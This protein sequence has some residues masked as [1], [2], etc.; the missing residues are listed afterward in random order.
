M[1]NYRYYLPASVRIFKS[2]G[3]DFTLVLFILRVHHPISM[4]HRRQVDMAGGCGP[5]GP[6]RPMPCGIAQRH[7][8]P[9][10]VIDPHDGL[11][12]ASL[13]LIQRMMLRSHRSLGPLSYTWRTKTDLQTTPPVG[14]LTYLSCNCHPGAI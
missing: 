9:C 13:P 5:I 1:D 14:K 7:P 11:H 12:T 10:H 4:K 2:S 8:G 6:C 3:Q